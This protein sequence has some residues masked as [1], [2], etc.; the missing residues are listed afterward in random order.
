MSKA[1]TFVLDTNVLLHNPLS[2][3]AFADNTVVLPM[4][5]IEEL[6]HMKNRS[7]EIG[8]NARSIIRSLDKLRNKGHLGDGVENEQGGM[9]KI[10]AA[11]MMKISTGLDREVA[12]NR[13]IQ[14]AYGLHKQGE[15]VIFVTKDINAR[16]KADAL[17]LEA[18]DYENE[19]VNIDELY[20][21]Y[22]TVQVESDIIDEF[23]ACESIEIDDLNAYPHEFVILQDKCNSKHTALTKCLGNGKLVHLCDK[24]SQAWHIKPRN[25]EQRLALE[26]LLDDRISFVSLVGQ[27]GSGKTLFALAAALELTLRQKSYDKIL[28][29][30]PIM[31]LGRDIGYLPGSKEA[32]LSNWMQPIFDN[33]TFLMRWQTLDFQEKSQKKV[34]GLIQENI[35]EIEALT[36]IR[37]RTIPRHFM[38]IDEAQNLS[39]HEIKTVVSRAGDGTKIVLTGDPYQIDNPYLDSNSNGLSYAAERLKE[40]EICGHITLRKSERSILAAIAAE[41]L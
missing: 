14:V 5:V 23:Y 2:L 38:I 27:A 4:A 30:R 28:V 40:Q 24:L 12:D 17:G 39:P 7:D 25:R 8:R 10:L 15:N 13:I 33:L 34:D 41:Q 1:K 26:L 16:I 36:Y 37:G 18:Q 9:V 21:G 3:D 11:H 20:T 32:K 29:S 6:D 35:I 31:P 19:K 22:R